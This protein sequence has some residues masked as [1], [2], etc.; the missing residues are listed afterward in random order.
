MVTSCQ[1]LKLFDLTGC[2]F[3]SN[4]TIQ[5]AV[6]AVKLRNNTIKLKLVVKS[7]LNYSVDISIFFICIHGDRFIDFK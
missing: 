1:D 5:A 6:D 3:V 7:E 4:A 2:D